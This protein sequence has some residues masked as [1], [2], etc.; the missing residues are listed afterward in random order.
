MQQTDL[1][2]LTIQEAAELLKQCQISPVE[3]TRAC[4]DR[5][6]S[7][8]HLNCFITL[9]AEDA[10]REAKEAETAIIKGEYR[11]ALHGIP[12]ALKDLY[13]VRGVPT[14]AASKFLLDNVATSDSTV[15]RK[16]REAGT[17]SLGKL[18]M[19]EWALGV[20]N[21]NSYFGP[22]ENPWHLG[23]FTGGSSGGSGAGLSADLFFGTMGSDTGGSVRIPAALCSIVGLK[24]TTGR[25]S[26]FGVIPLSWTL[27][28][29]GPMARNVSDVAILM[30]A[31]AGYDANDP[32]CVDVPGD[33]YVMH[34][35]EGVKGWHV[36]LARDEYFNDA[37][38]EVLA[39]VQEA[40]RVF[41]QLGAH[42][43][44]VAFPQVPEARQLMR[45]ILHGDAAAYH[46]ERLQARPEDFGPDVLPRLQDGLTITATEYALAR[47]SQTI[48]RRQSEAFMAGYDVLLTPTA[49][50]AATARDDVQGLERARASMSRFTS[51][52]N[53]FGLP[54]LSVP[55]GF[56]ASGLPLGL[57]IVGAPWS[58]AKLLRAGYAYEQA[59]P[60]HLKKPTVKEF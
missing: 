53:V 23:Y 50:M 40:A 39:A 59:T 27:D 57:Q 12:I 33:D 56:T 49:P 26:T 35:A 44:E 51:P 9:T 55:C 4:L 1:T 8:K 22:P 58:E 6:N 20:T 31:V 54:A 52:F 5:I 60:W 30:Q 14:T 47:H 28:H 11:G 45:P 36:A 37:D 46:R 32:T 29:A 16:L 15:T 43:T 10:L 25:V 21:L 38:P 18:N 17:I 41:E 3:L 34:L 13:D 42:V 48:L 2:A 24:P 7:L 19:H